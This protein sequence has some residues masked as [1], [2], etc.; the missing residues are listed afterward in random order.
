MNDLLK[1]AKEATTLA[2]IISIVDKYYKVDT[3]LKEMRVKILC[4][5]LPNIIEMLN[6]EKRENV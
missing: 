4:S 3:P 5:Q 1:E 2:E 6:L